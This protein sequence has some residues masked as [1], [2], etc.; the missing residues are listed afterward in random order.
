MF[1]DILHKVVKVVKYIYKE[2]KIMVEKMVDA[3]NEVELAKIEFAEKIYDDAKNGV[4]SV[5]TGTRDGAKSLVTGTT[6]GIKSVGESVVNTITDII[7]DP[8]S[9]RTAAIMLIAIASGLLV[10]S[11]FNKRQEQENEEVIIDGEI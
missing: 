6:N 2:A 9:S 10:N 3:K 7:N 1:K 8:D 4:K 11:F 5:A